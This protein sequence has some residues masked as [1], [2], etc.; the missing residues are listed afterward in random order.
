M[1]IIIV[2]ENEKGQRLD[3]LLSKYMNKAPK[4]FL[5]K[6]LRKK[7]ITLN[8]ARAEGSELLMCGDEI[9]LYLADETI[10][11]FRESVQVALVEMEPDIIFED[12]NFLFINKPEGI[13]SQKAKDADIS[14][15]EILISYLVKK[16]ELTQKQLESFRPSVCN[17]LD[18]NTTGL[19]AAGKTLSAL[20]MLSQL[21]K[22]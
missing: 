16:G 22:E 11:K 6:M 19:L 21:F 7:N 20:Q 5:Y 9:R 8:G 14:M 17:R 18:R 3:K 2:K 4:S 1:Q 13:L 12:D 15:V 10:E